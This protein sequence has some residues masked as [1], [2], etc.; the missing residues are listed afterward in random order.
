MKPTYYEHV[1]RIASEKE[2]GITL[3]LTEKDL[4][5]FPRQAIK[6]KDR[7]QHL[8]ETYDKTVRMIS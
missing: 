8:Q 1:K 3:L 6:G 4:M 5:V 7:E 2:G